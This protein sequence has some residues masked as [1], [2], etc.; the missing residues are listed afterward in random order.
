MQQRKRNYLLLFLHLKNF[1]NTWSVH[2][3]HAV[4]KY[5]LQKKDAKPRLLRLILLLQEFDTEIKDKRGVE[6][7]VADHL[8]RIRVEDD[9]PI[10]DFLPTKN[11]YNVDSTF[12]GQICLKYEEPP[13]DTS[14]G[15]SI[16]TPDK[17]QPDLT[18]NTITI[19]VQISVACNPLATE[20]DSSGDRSLSRG[21]ARDR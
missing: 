12:I 13:I 21:G 4:L 19:D 1:I 20:S 6:N 11:V 18:P 5:L 14:N 9:V 15:S 17:Q 16:D 3:D 2:T 7:G 8:S 10:D